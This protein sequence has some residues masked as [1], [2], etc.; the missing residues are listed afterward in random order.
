MDIT[1]NT[2]KRNNTE[3]KV[4]DGHIANNDNVKNKNF[5][6]KNEINDICFS[7]YTSIKLQEMNEGDHIEIQE[8][9]EKEISGS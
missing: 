9:F 8:E 3:A 6:S 4:I 2:K 5:S 1:S 7:T